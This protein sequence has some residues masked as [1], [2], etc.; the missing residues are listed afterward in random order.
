MEEN[1]ENAPKR[2][3]KRVNAFMDGDEDAIDYNDDDPED[4][5]NFT[6]TDV[7]YDDENPDDEK[8]EVESYDSEINE[9]IPDEEVSDDEDDVD[10]NESDDEDD[11]EAEND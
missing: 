10:L 11:D 2:K 6:P 5:D 8:S 1:G 4:E 3:R 7:E 9:I